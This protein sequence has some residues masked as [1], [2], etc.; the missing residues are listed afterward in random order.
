MKTSEIKL[1]KYYADGKGNVRLVS[2]E[3]PEFK[4][5]THQSDNDCVQFI[6]TARG[7]RAKLPVGSVGK[8]T[9]NSF[10]QWAKEEFT[11]PPCNCNVGFDKFCNWQGLEDPESD[12]TT[13]IEGKSYDVVNGVDGWVIYTPNNQVVHD[14]VQWLVGEKNPSLRGKPGAV[15][16]DEARLLAEVFISQDFNI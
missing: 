4:T 12:L 3:G 5:W 8:M 16:R 15:S 2:A 10:A 6:V 13:T 7:K 11:P 9:R 1:N 14:G